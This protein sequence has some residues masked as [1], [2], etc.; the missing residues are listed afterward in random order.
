[1]ADPDAPAWFEDEPA[2]DGDVA[3]DGEEDTYAGGEEA[4]PAP[5]EAPKPPAE[6]R[7]TYKL[8]VSNSTEFTYISKYYTVFVRRYT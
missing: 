1:M 3:A 7:K 6:W 4:K 8:D 2:A 5:V